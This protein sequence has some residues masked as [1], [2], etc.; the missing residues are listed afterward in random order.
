MR[1]I[2]RVI[3]VFLFM[4]A[5]A[6]SGYQVCQIQHGYAAQTDIDEMYWQFRPEST[7]ET[8]QDNTN[9]DVRPVD[10]PMVNFKNERIQSLRAQ[11]REAVGWITI[12]HT[13]I[14]YPF[15]HADDNSY[16][17]HKKLD[18]EYSYAGT[19][20]MD[21]RNCADFT[22]TNT[23]LYGHNMKNGSM[24]ASLKRFGKADFFESNQTGT[25]YLEDKTFTIEIFAYMVVK[26]SDSIIYNNPADDQSMQAFV[27]YIEDNAKHY[28]DIDSAPTDRFITLSTCSYEFRDARSVLIGRLCQVE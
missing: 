24:F 13:G 7:M 12:A 1:R 23:I 27:D 2:L 25:I 18:G 8:P 14:D 17:L 26:P 9:V 19:I 3:V 6:Y 28:R 4:L 5:I 15:V 21:C 22:D 20:F 11:H 10:A 16:Y